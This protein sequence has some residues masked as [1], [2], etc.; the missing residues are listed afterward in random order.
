MSIIGSL[1]I[2]NSMQDETFL[3]IAYG[4]YME[5]FKKKAKELRYNKGWVQEDLAR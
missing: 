1:Y 3:Y 5:Q 4:G 2:L